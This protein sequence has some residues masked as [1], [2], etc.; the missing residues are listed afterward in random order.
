MVGVVFEFYFGPHY[1]AVITGLVLALVLTAMRYVRLWEWRGRPTGLFLVRAV[2]LTCVVL[3]LLRVGAKP[4]RIPLTPVYPPTWCCTLNG[5]SDRAR[6]LEELT[7]MPGR[8]LV[9][10]R[11]N[12]NHNP[13]VEWVY[14]EAD[15]DNAKVVWA[16][17]MDEPRNR[18]LMRYFKD[19]QVW[20]VE[21]DETPPKMSTYPVSFNQ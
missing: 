1:V 4:L 15:I 20:L 14:N 13:D 10:V 17:Q 3:V 7:R 11:Y 16:R 6:F 9:V 19:R 2:P 8:Q 18:E 12:A 21:P 5:N